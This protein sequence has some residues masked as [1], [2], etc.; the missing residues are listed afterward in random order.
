VKTAIVTAA[1]N[2]QFKSMLV[3]SKPFFEEYANKTNSDFIYISDKKINSRYAH[4]EKFQMY[5]LLQTYNRIIFFDC[6]I[7]VMDTAPNLFDIVPKDYIGAVYDNPKNE[8]SY[9][10]RKK[11]IQYIKNAF[12]E[13][14]WNSEYINSGVLVLSSIHKKIFINPEDRLKFNSSYKDQTLINYNIFKN[15]FKIY[16]LHNTFNCMPLF[17][18]QEKTIIGGFYDKISHQIPHVIHFAGLT[19]K[20]EIINKSIKWL[21]EHK[22]IQNENILETIKKT[23]PEL[24]TIDLPKILDFS[25]GTK[26]NILVSPQSKIE[27]TLTLPTNKSIKKSTHTPSIDPSILKTDPIQKNKLFYDI[28]ELGWAMYLSAHV[29]YLSKNGETIAVSCPKSREVLYRNKCSKILPIPLDFILEYGHLPSDGN[30]LF[31]PI[32]NKRIRT[33]DKF[34]TIFKKAYP[35]YE[36]ATNYSKFEK[37]RIF[38][39]YE[40]TEEIN[41]ICNYLFKTLPVIMVFPRYRTSKFQARNISKE[42]WINIILTLIK[43]FPNSIIASIGAPNGAYNITE[44]NEI[45]FFNGV[46]YDSDKMLDIMVSLCNTKQGVVAIGNQSGPLKIALQ[47]GCPAYIFGNE[48][49][50]HTID[51]N[52]ANTEVQFYET[53]ITDSGFVIDNL[54]KMKEEIL[55]FTNLQLSKR[56]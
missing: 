42:F 47:C 34:A 52:W 19:N 53:K 36:I 21:I 24:F 43:K 3:Y 39:A 46:K 25:K 14:N 33:H 38:E 15:Q 17:W 28:S 5:E 20:S 10:F 12:G 4:L 22:Y 8:K 27:H 49:K 16:R 2:D 35:E 56:G 45:N 31:D 44:I 6:D 29:N 48:K 30:H 40:S 37:C 18:K 54:H 51:E 32:T 41:N 13:N 23:I 11:E 26:R 7:I 55:D 9:M 50:R 1:I